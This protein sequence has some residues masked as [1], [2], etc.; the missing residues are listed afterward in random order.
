MGVFNFLNNRKQST[1]EVKSLPPPT[2]FTTRVSDGWN[3]FEIVC[4]SV[5]L[6][7]CVSVPKPEFQHVGQVE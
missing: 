5:C 4:V 2:L 1:F 7:V 6:S 3:S